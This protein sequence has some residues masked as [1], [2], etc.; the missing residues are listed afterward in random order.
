MNPMTGAPRPQGEIE[1]TPLDSRG[2]AVVAGVIAV[3]ATVVIVDGGYLVAL[4][5]AGIA[6]LAIVRFEFCVYAQILLLPW[7]PFLNPEFSVRDVTVILRFIFFICVCIQLARKGR[8]IQSWI[9]SH[10]NTKVAI[11]AVIM[12]LSLIV[13]NYRGTFAAYQNL[14][15]ML[16]YIAFYYGIAGWLETREQVFK[17]VK[18]VLVS[19]IV[20]SLFGFCQVVADGFTALYF[21]INPMAADILEELGGWSGRITSLLFHSNSLAGYLNLVVPLAMACFM[22]GKHAYVRRLGLVCAATATAALYFTGSRGGWIAYGFML[23]AVY[24][25]SSPRR[26]AVARL[27]IVLAL[28]AAIVVTLSLSGTG[29]ASQ[30]QFAV[31]A[32]RAQ[33]VDAFTLESRLALWNAAAQMFVQH[34]VLGIGFGNYRLHFQEYIP[35]IDYALDAHSLYLQFLSETGIAGFL[36]FLLVSWSFLRTGGRLARGSDELYRIIGVAAC[37]AVTATLAHGGVDYLYG[38]SPQFGNMFFLA[39]AL[40]SVASELAA[41]TASP[42]PVNDAHG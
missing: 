8:S 30:D 14:V 41:R 9:F 15:K 12:A 34:P 16:S 10:L 39:L 35:G 7:Y 20:V 23:L 28:A 24:W 4:V 2:I 11:M 3:L 27:A 17:A 33:E 42:V 13:S 26:E 31:Q 37:G 36:S 19:T 6:I 1:A 18:L 40:T 5:C 21:H 22:I 25:Y 32:G 38:V 29:M